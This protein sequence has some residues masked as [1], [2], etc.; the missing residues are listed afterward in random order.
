MQGFGD[1]GPT[2]LKT[3]RASDPKSGPTVTRRWRARDD[4]A[5][6]LYLS[7]TPPA[8]DRVYGGRWSKEPS[9]GGFTIVSLTYAGDPTS[10]SFADPLSDEWELDAN[11]LQK[12]IW[13][14][15]KVVAVFTSGGTIDYAAFFQWKKGVEQYF[16]GEGTDGDSIDSLIPAGAGDDIKDFLLNFGKGQRSYDVSQ[17]VLRNTK[18][19]HNA[20]TLKVATDNV[21]RFYTTAALVRVEGVPNSLKF[22]MPDGYW[23]RRSPKTKIHTNGRETLS[24]EFWHADDYSRFSYGAPIA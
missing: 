7:E 12:D 20:S 18:I 6:E 23:Q 17:F 13:G 10:S 15:P 22:E 16:K 1:I 4:I 3:I 14:D 11:E 19:V 8:E 2:E 5:E 24:Q 9:D 21:L